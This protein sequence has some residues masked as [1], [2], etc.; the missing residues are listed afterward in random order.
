MKKA[1]DDFQES[2]PTFELYLINPA[3]FWFFIKHDRHKTENTNSKLKIVRWKTVDD[4]Q[5]RQE[6]RGFARFLMFDVS[7]STY[8]S[9]FKHKAYSSIL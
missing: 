4:R 6:A 7:K 3:V 2:L 5:T 9:N 1:G 8:N